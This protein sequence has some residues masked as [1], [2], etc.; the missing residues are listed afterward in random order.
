MRE[1]ERRTGSRFS[2]LN[3]VGRIK[4]FEDSSET[5]DTIRGGRRYV[6]GHFTDGDVLCLP[7]VSPPDANQNED[8]Q[9]LTTGSNA[10][11]YLSVQVPTCPR[12]HRTDR[13][14]EL[15]S[16]HEQF[17]GGRFNL[18][19]CLLFLVVCGVE[20]AVIGG[21]SGFRKGGSTRAQ[22]IWTMSWFTVGCLLGFLIHNPRLIV[23][24]GQPD[25]MRQQ[26]D[27][28]RSTKFVWILM[29]SVPSVGG[30]VMV[31]QM[32]KEYGSCYN[33]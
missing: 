32:M 22:Q 17:L 8:F 14:H 7:S 1:A 18:L 33:V 19:D 2:N 15:T 5:N 27:E 11:P 9:V 25:T 3:V 16:L 23:F 29:S 20:I 21:L 13:V 31:A 10:G 24:R 12:F 26:T 28:I 6:I 30:F 4:S